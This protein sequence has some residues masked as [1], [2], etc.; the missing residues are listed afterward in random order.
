MIR[1]WSMARC[2]TWEVEVGRVMR[3][4]QPRQ[5]VSMMPF[6]TLVGCG[7]MCLS[8]QLRKEAQMGGS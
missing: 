1:N 8:F 5:K 3:L 6:Q 4:G 2:A 7:G